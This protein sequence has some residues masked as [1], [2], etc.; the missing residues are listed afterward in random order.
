MIQDIEDII[1]FT[2]EG[3]F[4]ALEITRSVSIEPE[5]E[6]SYLIIRGI[7][8]NDEYNFKMTYSSLFMAHEDDTLNTYLLD[9]RDKVFKRK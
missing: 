3:S 2:L 9:E 5:I 1:F 7:A 6:E 4:E 8:G